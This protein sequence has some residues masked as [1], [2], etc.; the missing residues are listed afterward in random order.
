MND[1][2]VMAQ[3]AGLRSNSSPGGLLLK[4][5]YRQK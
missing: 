5:K 3:G 4:R 1:T 2:S